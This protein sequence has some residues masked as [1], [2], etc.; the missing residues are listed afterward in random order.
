MLQEPGEGTA[1]RSSRSCKEEYDFIVVDSHPVLAATDSLLLGQHVDAVLL[2]LMRDVSRVLHVY[3]A[4][5]S[6]R[7]WASACWAP[8]ST[9]P[10]PKDVYV[11]GSPPAVPVA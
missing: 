1:G 2:S 5:S 3:A 11:G 9:A 8:W 10:T 7:R 6:W 4:A